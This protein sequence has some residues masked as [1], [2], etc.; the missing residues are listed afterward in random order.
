MPLEKLSRKQKGFFYKPWI[1]EGIKNSMKTGDYLQVKKVNEKTEESEK[2]YKRYK[3]FV[4]RLQNESYDN[5]YT[6][7]VKKNF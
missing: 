1:T 7:K 2:Y 3:K 6:N 4:T 5:Y